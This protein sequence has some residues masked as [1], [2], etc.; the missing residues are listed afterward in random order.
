M[1]NADPASSGGGGLGELMDLRNANLQLRK[2][3]HEREA[4]LRRLTV[5]LRIREQALARAA[6]KAGKAGP[7]GAAVAE[8]ASTAPPPRRRRAASPLLHPCPRR[9]RAL[10]EG[11]AAAG[12][13]SLTSLPASLSLLASS[14]SSPYS[15]PPS[16]H[17]ALGQASCC[18]SPSSTS[19]RWPS[20]ARSSRR[21]G[22]ATGS[23]PSACA[24]SR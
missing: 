13:R 14:P 12:P 10:P 4:A 17:L 18:T 1:E 15:R 2:E 21:C 6:A 20:R 5:Q 19:R 8:G 16:R 23:S 24:C 22:A 9:H 3:R 7:A 11:Q